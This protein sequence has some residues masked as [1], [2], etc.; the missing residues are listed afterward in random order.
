MKFIELWII[1]CPD[2]DW[3][4]HPE[5]VATDTIARV[6]DARKHP[7]SGERY[8]VVELKNGV[9]L[10]LDES[11]SHLSGRIEKGEMRTYAGAYG[12]A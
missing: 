1:Q 3:Y 6:Y 12:K 8:A 10:Y 2:E 9:K 11:Y 7:D 4:P 5:M